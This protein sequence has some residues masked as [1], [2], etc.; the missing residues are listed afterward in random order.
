[1][2]FS[3]RSRD[4]FLRYQK[5]NFYNLHKKRS[6]EQMHKI[7]KEIGSFYNKFSP[8]GCSRNFLAVS[9]DI[10]SEIEKAKSY[11]NLSKSSAYTSTS[12]NRQ[13]KNFHVFP[14]LGAVQK[15]KIT[16][17][18]SES[19]KIANEI[20]ESPGKI[21]LEEKV[22][23]TLRLRKINKIIFRCKGIQS[24]VNA[25]SEEVK[26]QIGNNI[27][28]FERLSKKL[29]TE[30]EESEIVTRCKE[31]CDDDRYTDSDIIKITKGLRRSGKKI[32]KFNHVAFMKGVDKVVCSFKQIKG[33]EM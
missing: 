32:W 17:Q 18:S 21:G 15:K 19:K 8:T 10:D 12:S 30:D 22:P 14:S 26:V 33:E 24:D 3:Q 7:F 20:L 1:M 11:G 27:N 13:K 9:S 5:E 16:L 28:K 4:I 6:P 25:E 2:E 23:K 29:K 31:H